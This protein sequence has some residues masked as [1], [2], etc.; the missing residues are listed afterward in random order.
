M[1]RAASHPLAYPLTV[2]I[3]ALV[4]I[5]AWAPFADL[6]QLSALLTVVLAILLYTAF[7]TG[8]ALGG[9]P[10]GAGPQRTIPVRRV[11][12][13]YRLLSRS[14]LEITERGR[15]RWLPVYFD[16]QLI[17]L[18]AA[19]AEVRGRRVTID[20]MRLYPAG[21][22]RETEP[23]GRLVDN[24]S[25]PPPD[26]DERA[27]EAVALS[28][29]LTLDAQSMVAAPFAGLLWVYVAGDGVAAFAGATCVAAIAALWLSAVRGSDPS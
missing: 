2:T 27:A 21:R 11:R 29:R 24:P 23:P 17:S 15:T 8:I 13:Q 28:R 19:E 6:D 1:T 7:R 12:Q 5:A 25:K 22:L 4:V 16:P 3:G 9:L 14:W 10:H 26:A 20:G 18:T